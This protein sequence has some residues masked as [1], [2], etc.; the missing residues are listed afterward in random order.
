M[1]TRSGGLPP[2]TTRGIPE[3]RPP[4]PATSRDVTTDTRSGSRAGWVVAVVLVIA[5][6]G[7]TTLFL[8]G[9]GFGS[10]GDGSAA[11]TSSSLEDRTASSDTTALADADFRELPAP[12]QTIPEAPATDAAAAVEGFLI[13]EANADYVASYAF[14]TRADQQLYASAAAWVA[15]HASVMPP[16]TAYDLGEVSEG[17]DGIQVATTVGFRP[18]LD[19]VVG[20]VPAQAEVVWAVQEDDGVFGVSLERSTLTPVYLDDSGVADAAAAW[21]ASQQDCAPAGE[22]GGT[23]LGVQ[24]PVLELCDAPGEVRLGEVTPLGQLEAT[25]F[26]TAFGEDSLSWARVVEIE[27]PVEFRAVLAPVGAEWRIIGALPQ[28]AIELTPPPDT[29]S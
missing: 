27:A 15:E 7:G 2:S 18:S 28:G 6:L 16:V 9:D 23:L 22:W 11:P 12:P 20:L 26:V 10:D 4:E 1:T 29:T 3:T 19:E 5:A 25:P 14:L 17:S 8:S 21:V 13:A 24:G